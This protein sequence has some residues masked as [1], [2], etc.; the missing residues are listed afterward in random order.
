MVVN[1]GSQRRQGEPTRAETGT[2]HI[3]TTKIILR[4]LH[5]VAL[6]SQER[7]KT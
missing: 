2:D 6:T 7:R 4:K 1:S 5:G 3:V